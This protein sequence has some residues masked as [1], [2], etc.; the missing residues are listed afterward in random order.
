[1]PPRSTAKGPGRGC[2]PVLFFPKKSSSI[3]DQS[4]GFQIVPGAE[5]PHPEDRTRSRG[6]RLPRHVRR[7]P[8]LGKSRPPPPRERPAGFRPEYEPSF[9]HP[10]PTS[11]RRRNRG[12]IRRRP[13]AWRRQNQEHHAFW[14]TMRS[15]PP[16]S[17]RYHTMSGPWPPS[18]LPSDDPA[19]VPAGQIHRLLLRSV[20]LLCSQKN[21]IIEPVVAAHDPNDAHYGRLVCK[22][23]RG[24]TVR[25]RNDT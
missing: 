2:S 6:S 25:H 8:L 13:E 10:W 5:T 22:M 18:R 1:M 7:D 3:E 20:Q 4:V 21:I 19:V 23:I 24:E 12:S 14:R 11:P 17:G 9:L 15:I 16:A